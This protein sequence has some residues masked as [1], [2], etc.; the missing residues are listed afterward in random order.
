MKNLLKEAHKLTREIKGEYPEVNYM[1]QLGICISYLS[2]KED[3]KKVS[4]RA[5]E[6]KNILNVTEEEA[7]LLENVEKYYQDEYA[8]ESKIGMNLWI[9]GDMRRVYINLPWR[10]RNANAQKNYFDLDSA[11]LHDR[12]VS[13][14]F[15]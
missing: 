3:S 14:S 4:E 15:R 7:I 6:I 5:V 2:E 9:K 13:K 11:F 12:Y 1:A 10:S 8:R